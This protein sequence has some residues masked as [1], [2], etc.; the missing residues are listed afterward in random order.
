MPPEIWDRV[1]VVT[2]P[3]LLGD[4]SARD[5]ATVE[6]MP[7]SVVGDDLKC[8]TSSSPCGSLA[9]SGGRRDQPVEQVHEAAEQVAEQV[10][11]SRDR[12]D[13]ERDLL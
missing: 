3:N 8:M 11:R 5:R 9:A 10:S 1:V 6:A 4:L 12:H 7:A 13:V 2:W